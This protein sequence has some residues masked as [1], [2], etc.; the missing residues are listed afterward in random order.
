MT[1]HR[2]GPPRRVGNSRVA[3]FPGVPRRLLRGISPA[4]LR[5]AREGRR[6]EVVDLLRPAR[7][8]P[9][10]DASVDK[11]SAL[12]GWE[13]EGGQLSDSPAATPGAETKSAGPRFR[14]VDKPGSQEH[15]GRLCVSPYRPR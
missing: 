15:D 5:V 13:D 2:S 10:N 7:R 14:R 12:S 6:C 3:N 8:E 1:D 9:A 11:A 4:D